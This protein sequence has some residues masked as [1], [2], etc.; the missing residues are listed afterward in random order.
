MINNNGFIGDW[1]K[2]NSRVLD[3]GC[4]DGSLLE[5]LSNKNQVRGYGLEIDPDSISQCI[6]RGV[7]VIEQDLNEGLENFADA[8]F[9]TVVMM[10]TLQALRYPHLVLDEMLRI[11][12]QCI[13][14]FPN[15]GHWRTRA[16]LV[17]SG[18]MPV[19][20]RLSYQWY[21]TPNIHFFTYKDF[22]ALCVERNINIVNRNFVGGRASDLGLDSI[23][24]NLFAHTAV[25]RLSK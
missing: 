14:T 23:W 2:E 21:D 22:E 15:F 11:G 18:R 20:K 25:Y 7:N 6:G 4:G 24:P 16:D 19:T 9:D 5:T 8:S 3:L 13:V 12:K 10:Q 17:F 1:I